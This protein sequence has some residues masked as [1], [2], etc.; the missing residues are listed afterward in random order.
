[1]TD[2]AGTPAF[3]TTSGNANVT[4]SNTGAVSVSCPTWSAPYSVSGTDSDTL[5]NSGT[6]SLTVVPQAGTL[7][8]TGP[9]SP[10][11]ITTAQAYSGTLTVSGNGAFTVTYA[12]SQLHVQR[13]A[14]V[15]LPDLLQRHDRGAERGGQHPARRRLCAHRY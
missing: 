7:T 1:M 11:S 10:A 15:A 12:E 3:T 14:P 2:S 9:T 13:H 4:V 6:W 8:Q 5:G